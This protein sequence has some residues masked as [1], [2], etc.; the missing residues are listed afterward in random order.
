MYKHYT[1]NTNPSWNNLS[2]SNIEKAGIT[3]FS[4]TSVPRIVRRSLAAFVVLS[5]RSLA[6]TFLASF[7]VLSQCSLALPFLNPR[8]VCRPLALPFS[9]TSVLSH[10]RSPFSR[11]VLI[12]HFHTSSRTVAYRTVAAFSRI[13]VI[14]STILS[15]IVLSHFCS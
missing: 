6:L 4:R 11:I 8:I 14:E 12:S 10:F 9:R 7:V 15:C 2:R 1:T 3:V 5:Q 13:V